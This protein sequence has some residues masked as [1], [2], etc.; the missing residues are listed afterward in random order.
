MLLYTTYMSN[1][2]NIP[3][4]ENTICILVTRWKPRNIINPSNYKFNI[5]WK[6]N[7]GPSEILLTRWKS[8][9]MNWSDYREIYLQEA[10]NS[11]TFISEMQ[12]IIKYLNEEKNVFLVCYE[13]DYIN[14]HRSILK[15]IF[16]YNNIECEEYKGV[17]NE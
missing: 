16:Q 2:K 3:N 7:L 8:G 6:P 10:S 14:C 1:I 4:D 5:I 13:K 12:E 11:N 9:N 17:P 15:E